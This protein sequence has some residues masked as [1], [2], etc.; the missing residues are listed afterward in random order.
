MK[1][2]PLPDLDGMLPGM[3]TLRVLVVDDNPAE[4]A[5]IEE[6]FAPYKAKVHVITATTA[7]LALAELMMI[8]DDERPQVAM[9]DINMPLISGFELAELLIG[10]DVPTILMSCQVDAERIERARAIGA[11]AV[12]DKPSNLEGYAAMAQQVLKSARLI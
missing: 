6:C 12:I 4:L 11:I 8:S 1:L 7:Q 5:L 9:V 2:A 3:P 10:Q